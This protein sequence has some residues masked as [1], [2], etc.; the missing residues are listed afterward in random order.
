MIKVSVPGWKDLELE[1]L[2]LDANGTIAVDGHIRPGIQ[3][4]V[5]ELAKSITVYV[6]SADT[7][8]TIDQE[9]EHLAAELVKITPP[10][11][12]KAKGDFVRQIGAEETVTIGNGVN[13]V[14]ML[15]ESALGIAVVGAEGAAAAAVHAADVVVQTPEDALDLLLNPVRLKATLRR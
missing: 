15:T 6:V 5:F 12:N 13:D 10:H 11:E 3:E 7:Y 14:L 9:V 8:G 1:N 2:V 4:K